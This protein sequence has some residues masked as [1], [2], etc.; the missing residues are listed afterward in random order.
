[1]VRVAGVSANFGRVPCSGVA[2][3]N[4][5]VSGL[6]LERAERCVGVQCKCITW[7]TLIKAVKH[8]EVHSLVRQGVWH[9][10]RHQP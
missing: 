1:M 3:Q 6:V 10:C 8:G 2:C 5:V 7:C 9:G 4:M